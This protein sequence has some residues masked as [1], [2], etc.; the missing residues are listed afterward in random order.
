MIIKEYDGTDF[1]KRP[2]KDFVE[3]IKQVLEDHPDADVSWLT[4]GRTECDSLIIVE[5]EL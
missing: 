4:G 3:E 2:L 1:R 5:K